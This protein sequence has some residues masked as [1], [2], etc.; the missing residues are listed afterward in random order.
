MLGRDALLVAFVIGHDNGD[1]TA[2]VLVEIQVDTIAVDEDVQALG[3]VKFLGIFLGKPRRRTEQ[4]TVGFEFVAVEGRV[5]GLEPRVQW[6]V[7]NGHGRW[8][9]ALHL[10][11]R[12]G[13]A[14]QIPLRGEG[15]VRRHQG[16][17][18]PGPMVGG[19]AQVAQAGFFRVGLKP[20]G[21]RLVEAL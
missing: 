19:A 5:D 8:Q 2:S 3:L 13:P 14:G 1:D 20:R 4:E 15:K 17:A 12:D 21:R 7:Q 11:K 6:Q 18:T 9:I 16:S 10:G